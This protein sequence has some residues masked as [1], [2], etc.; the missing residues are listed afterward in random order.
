MWSDGWIGGW[1]DGWLMFKVTNIMWLDYFAA[2]FDNN[3]HYCKIRQQQ[4]L[5]QHLTTTVTIAKFDN[6]SHYCNI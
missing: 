1:L 6:N 3:S 2:T 4:S 5:L